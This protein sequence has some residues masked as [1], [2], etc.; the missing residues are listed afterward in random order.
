MDSRLLVVSPV[1]RSSARCYWCIRAI[2]EEE[3]G[4]YVQTC[5]HIR[6][7]NYRV[8]LWGLITFVSPLRCDIVHDSIF[9][10]LVGTDGN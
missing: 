2:A 4:D 6:V 8:L 5:H 9:A 7:L 1:A 10:K 3:K